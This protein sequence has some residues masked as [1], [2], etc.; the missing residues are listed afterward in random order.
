MPDQP[1]SECFG[2]LNGALLD[3]LASDVALNSEQ[4]QIRIV[5]FG[6][7]GWVTLHHSQSGR[8]AGLKCVGYSL[9]DDGNG[10]A[11]R[12]PIVMLDTK[13]PLGHY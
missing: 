2:V 9:K 7:S 4:A 13:W 11:A 8:A 6:S 12:Q 5:S 3:I 10:G 1:N